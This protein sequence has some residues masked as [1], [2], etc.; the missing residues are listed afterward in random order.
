MNTHWKKLSWKTIEIEIRS[1]RS[2]RRWMSPANWIFSFS[3]LFGIL[4]SISLF[5][6]QSEHNQRS[7]IYTVINCSSTQH[8][9][10][11]LIAQYPLFSAYICVCKMHS[12][13]ATSNRKNW[14]AK[15]GQSAHLLFVTVAANAAADFHRYMPNFG[16]L[17]NCI[18]HVFVFASHRICAF[19][20]HI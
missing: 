19:H 17:R 1:D 20:I 7:S 15:I 5:P 18:F 14:K 16:A 10:L 8:C 11:S 3:L 2:G 4:F 12:I 13:A 6:N 9:S